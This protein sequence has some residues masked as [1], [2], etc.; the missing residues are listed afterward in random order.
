MKIFAAFHFQSAHCT[1]AFQ[2]VLCIVFIRYTEYR[3]KSDYDRCQTNI[4]VVFEGGNIS[5]VDSNL[6]A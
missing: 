1:A 4:H 6:S 3:V 2:A 5:R